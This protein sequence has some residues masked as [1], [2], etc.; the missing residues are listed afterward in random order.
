[1]KASIPDA[2]MV[3]RLEGENAVIRMKG[4]GSCRKRGVAAAGLC[5]GGL[6]Q[7]LTVRNPQQALVGDFV[8]IGLVQRVQFKGYLLA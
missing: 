1:M 7:V 3:I 6:P 5:T 8:K 4:D 2:G